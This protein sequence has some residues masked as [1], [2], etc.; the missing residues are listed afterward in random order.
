[1]NTLKIQTVNTVR[2]ELD[3]QRDTW[4]SK[5]SSWLGNSHAPSIAVGSVSRACL[6]AWR[7]LPRFC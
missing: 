2:A 5:C 7:F 1:M 4:T 3:A 6:T